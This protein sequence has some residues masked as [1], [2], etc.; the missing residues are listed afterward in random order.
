MKKF[1]KNCFIFSLIVAL[2]FPLCLGFSFFNEKNE[3]LLNEQ[4]Y[5]SSVEKLAKNVSFSTDLT[6]FYQSST[7]PSQKTLYNFLVVARF[8]NEVETMKANFPGT[9]L[10]YYEML[11][12]MYND[13]NSYSV[14]NYYKEVSN[15]KINLETV[16]VFED[17][18]IQ[19]SKTRNTYG[20]KLRNNN[21][22]YD[23][24]AIFLGNVSERM[25]LEYSLY[26]EICGQAI[27]I[28]SSSQ[29]QAIADGDNN[30]VV[31][32]LSVILLPDQSS[33]NVS[34][35]DLLWAHS[36][37][38][39]YW[40]IEN[41]AGILGI[42]ISNFKYSYM[43]GTEKKTVYIADFILTTMENSIGERGVPDNNT[44]IH[45]LGHVLGFPDYYIYDKQFTGTDLEDETWSVGVWDIMGYNHL[46]YA[47]YPLTYNRWLQG[48]LKNESVTEIKKNG[49][50]TLKPVSYE[51]LANQPLSSRTIAYKIVNP[52]RESESIWFEFRL[53]KDG[54][55]ENNKNWMNDGLIV[56]RVDTGFDY[57]IGYTNS[58]SP[59]N[60]AAAPY[61]VY[62][63]RN[64]LN[65]GE[66][67][68]ECR[69]AALNMDN[70]S[71]GDGKSYDL[72]YYN[73]DGSTKKLVSTAQNITWQFFDENFACQSLLLSTDVTYEN[74][75]IKVEVV[76]MDP[77]TMEL[78]FKVEWDGFNDA[79]TRNDL[80]DS[81]LYNGLLNLAGKSQDS[82]LSV[83]DFDN[84]AVLDL[85]NLKISSVKGL[86][87]FTFKNLNYIDLGGN[88]I[89]DISS[90]KNI[91]KYHSG[92][93]INLNNNQIDLGGLSVDELNSKNFIFL[94][95]QYNFAN[96]AILF[97]ETISL[98]CYIKSSYLNFFK[99]TFN[100]QDMESG[101]NIVHSYSDAQTYT[102]EITPTSNLF[103]KFSKKL[104]IVK[105][106][107]DSTN[108]EIERNSGVPNLIIEGMSQSDFE[109]VT[110]NIDTSNITSTPITI[111]YTV[112][113]KNNKAYSKT[114]SY[115]FMI[116]DNT[117]PIIKILG[118]EK[119]EILYNES[120][121]LPAKEI[122]IEDNGDLDLNY[123]FVSEPQ[124]SDVCIW[125]K[126][127]YKAT[128]D[129]LLG[130]TKGEQI[131]SINTSNC[132]NYIIEYLA[133][134]GEGNV[135][136]AQ[137]VI[138]INSRLIEKALFEDENL[139]GRICTLAGTESVYETSLIDFDFIDLASCNIQ[140]LVGI[141]HLIFKDGSLI[142]LSNNF[143]NDVSVLNDVLEV[144]NIEKINLIFNDVDSPVLNSKFI[145]GFQ[146]LKDEIFSK[147]QYQNLSYH[148]MNDFDEYFTLESDLDDEIITELGEYKVK[149]N[150]T[151]AFPS[152]QYS[153][154]YFDY[155]ISDMIEVEVKTQF[156]IEDY[157]E[158]LGVNYTRYTTQVN[159]T[160]VAPNKLVESLF[161]GQVKL[162]IYVQNL[163]L[164]SLDFELRVVDTTSPNI[165]LI[166]SSIIY[167]KKN[168]NYIEYGCNVFDNLDTLDYNVKGDVD[169]STCGRYVLTYYAVDNSGNSSNSL[170]RVVYV[171]D[172]AFLKDI[173]IEYNS[174][175]DVFDYLVFEQYRLEDF[176]IIENSDI[177]TSILGNALLN[178]KLEHKQ[179]T[180]LIFDL[181][182]SVKIVDKV[183][184]VITLLGGDVKLF[185]KSN[186]I[187]PGFS[188]TDNHDQNLNSRVVVTTN[189]DTSQVGEYSI[190]YNVSDS[191]GNQAIQAVRRVMVIYRPINSLKVKNAGIKMGYKVGEKVSFIAELDQFDE[192]LN[193]M[194][195]ILVWS[196]DGVEVARG[197]QKEFNFT[198]EDK[199]KHEIVVAVLN[200]QLDGEIVSYS[201]EVFNIHIEDF[202]FL[203]KYGT[204]IIVSGSILVLA[205]IILAFYFRRRN[206]FF[207]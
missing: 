69:F 61:N 198:F 77:D 171:G 96:D 47:Q 143:I 156:D 155:E 73:I 204:T 100:G 93:V 30:N 129:K 165:S 109:I 200:E 11:Q 192:E 19:L 189:L 106:K 170:E 153:F 92:I 151:N 68:D 183:K 55:F 207:Q 137:R 4:N 99:I 32:C 161:N 49:T 5:N 35:G 148:L 173:E 182:T 164:C 181:S 202:G 46:T 84:F 118:D 117:P 124:S 3:N 196:V 199:G 186:Y 97:D 131:N 34:W 194:N 142:D 90:L 8:K 133:I 52:N 41:T 139:Y 9:D 206:R 85:S 103:S 45:E 2:F 81:N 23:P 190:F 107:P 108:M 43:D 119:I 44:D 17:S 121:S 197:V 193:N 149:F 144:S 24:E 18:S 128:Y 62:V 75:G 167:L 145:F 56:Y 10:T 191:S 83:G 21:V 59:G 123:S 180:N 166:G 54:S 175:A 28:I 127:Y 33:V 205:V 38:L 60:I 12:K 195:P 110:S 57:A 37:S 134:D 132:G 169:T 14:K 187:E 91:T 147:K 82:L 80:T 157:F 130:Y 16:F 138:V 158:I 112:T 25:Y 26:N 135:G 101:A 50:Y 113:Y 94:I 177:D 53:Q 98:L 58:I 70:R 203:D 140:S 88:N 125:T 172:V 79:V 114:V 87:L 74:T 63:F 176:E 116:V 40:E 86:E 6:N 141:E 122:E 15:N 27:G 48:W 67:S 42:D 89:S 120:L 72:G 150:S 163:L 22:G 174:T 102:F 65:Y 51:K 64:Q 168:S 160:L 111:D 66:A 178:I 29:Y 20:N 201:S 36:L 104:S 71:M 179:E 188:A 105:M 146:G 1:K 76:S 185:I 154:Y 39:Y 159:S 95:Q 31:D 152:R 13:E 162:N 78:S 136:Y 184:P 7:L 115:S 126:N